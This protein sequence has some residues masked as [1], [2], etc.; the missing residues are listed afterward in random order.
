MYS[1]FIIALFMVQPTA[2][3]IRYQTPIVPEFI[4]FPKG[5]GTHEGI[6]ERSNHTAYHPGKQINARAKARRLY[7]MEQNYR[8]ERDPKVPEVVYPVA[9]N[10]NLKG[11]MVQQVGFAPKH[12]EQAAND[13]AH[14]DSRYTHILEGNKRD[15]EV[16]DA[17]YN[18]TWFVFGKQATCVN[19]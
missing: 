2:R 12:R 10:A 1:L 19:V 17:F 8:N 13:S 7:L 6:Y 18:W 4:R 11:V 3:G 14:Y 16:Q 9:A 15:D 5:D